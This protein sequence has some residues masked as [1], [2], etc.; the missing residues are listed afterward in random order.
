M[1]LVINLKDPDG[2][3]DSLEEAGIK[4]NSIE[5]HE[6]KDAIRKFIGYLEY[7]SIEIDTIEST[8]KVLKC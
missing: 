5:D 8:A 2:V 6:A 7:V 4:V 1:K 3:Y